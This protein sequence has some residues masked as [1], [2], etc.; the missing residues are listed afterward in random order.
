LSFAALS[1]SLGCPELVAKQA[2]G[3]PGAKK[4]GFTAMLVAVRLPVCRSRHL[5]MIAVKAEPI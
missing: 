4:A 2:G 3:G 1:D 5:M